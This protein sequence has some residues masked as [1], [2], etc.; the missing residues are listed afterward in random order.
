MIIALEEW[1]ENGR[2]TLILTTNTVLANQ[3]KQTI[4]DLFPHHLN[5]EN[6]AEN[7]VDSAETEGNAV[8]VVNALDLFNFKRNDHAPIRVT[9]ISSPSVL[10]SGAF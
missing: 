3:I 7:N 1:F 2:R 5:D 9:T 10:N 4:W 6:T 8:N